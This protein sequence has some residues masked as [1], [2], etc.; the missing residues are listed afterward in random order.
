MTG[1]STSR[2]VSAAADRRSSSRAK[3]VALLHYSSSPIVGGVQTVIERQA[4]VLLA[5]GHRVRLISGAGEARPDG[6]EFLLIPGMSSS[7]PGPV[8][9]DAA[10]LRR[11]LGDALRD[12]DTVV[13][14]NLF[15]FHLNMPL[16][17]VLWG[18]AEAA[19]RRQ[20]WIAWTHDLAA[21][22]PDAG[23]P[24]PDRQPWGLLRT[25]H[26]RC[27]Y[28]AVSAQRQRELHRL[29]GIAIGEVP[30]VPNPV[31][32]L[33]MAGG[34]PRLETLARS[35]GWMS[36]FPLLFYPARV[37]PRKRVELAVEAV[38]C[39]RTAW[40]GA[41]LVVTGGSNPH[42]PA[43]VEA[44][45]A[46]A[47]AVR[48]LGMERGVTFVADAWEPDDAEVAALYRLC[49]MLVFTSRSEGFGI[50][51]L[52]AS[53]ARMPMVC[54]DIEPLNEILP[55]RAARFAAD[56][57]AEFIAERIAEQIAACPGLEAAFGVRSRFSPDAVYERFLL[58]LLEGR[59]PGPP[60][61]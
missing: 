8:K 27:R 23:L 24:G 29:L 2:R 56:A 34:S 13:V 45:D 50:P 48:R 19:P 7:P 60:V 40:P 4:R 37:I 35:R 55:P 41:H 49:D 52:E 46:A 6:V 18:M 59:L 54:T 21:D 28:V 57:G 47:A 20:R 39:L 38:G 12:A 43:S 58:P 11:A 33:A 1:S 53:L 31:D 51:I 44:Y 9:R 22:N 14:H 61:A 15:T 10:S 3:V 5:H 30:V 42:L 36:A 32:P 16:T 25:A 26:P 17:A